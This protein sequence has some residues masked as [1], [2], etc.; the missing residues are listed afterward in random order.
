MSEAPARP[1]M[2]HEPVRQ[3][4]LGTVLFVFCAS[5]LLPPLLSM[6]LHGSF[7]A[8]P[9]AV[10][11]P[12]ALLIPFLAWRRMDRLKAAIELFLLAF[13]ASLAVL[14]LTY[15]AMRLRFPLADSGLAAA[16]AL[17]GYHSPSVVAWLETQPRLARILGATYGSF[18]PQLLLLP[19]L[20]CVSGRVAR[21]YG[22][23]LGYLLLG[24][25][26]SVICAFF[27]SEGA[28]VHYGLAASDFSGVNP[29]MGYL[30]LD[31]F[32]A[33]RD[34]PYFTL[35]LGNAAGIVTFPSGHAGAAI[36]CA[37]AA[38]GWRWMRWPFLVLNLGMYLSALSHGAHYLIDVAGGTAV[39]LLSIRIVT[40]VMDGR[41]P[42][43]IAATRRRFRTEPA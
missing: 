34:D 28:Y 1:A 33:V 43:L 40:I 39:A 17:I 25:F 38:W 29:K 26:G 19:V 14:A 5:L 31:S 3:V 22:M 42:S 18:M 8:A 2:E 6:R 30:F 13:L 37:W 32:H 9:M 24:I 27:P 7:Y 20:L 41:W 35:E 21:G 10:F 23:V 4:L 11:G 16:D 12:F 36:L 15:A